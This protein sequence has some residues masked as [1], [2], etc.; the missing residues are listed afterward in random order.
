MKSNS[1]RN[2]ILI[3]MSEFIFPALFAF[4]LTLIF[5]VAAIRFFPKWGLMDRP[6][7]YGLKRKPIPYYGGLILVIVFVITSLLFVEIDKH[8]LGVILGALM[9]AGISFLDDLRNINPWIRLLVQILAAVTIV[10]SGIGI[11]SITN[12]LGGVIEL[13]QFELSIP[14]GDDFYQFTIL[15][16]LF[17]IIWIVLIVNTMNFLDGLNGLVSGIGVIASFTVFMLSIRPDNLIDQTTV[18]TLAIILGTV[19]LAFW[20]FDFHPAKILMGDTGSMFIGFL[21]AVFAIFS[22][23]KI[24]TA[25]L[26]LGFPILDAF[27]VITRRIVRGRSP[28]QGDLKHL[29]HRLLEVGLTER[30]A[31]ILM[32]LLSAFFGLSAIFLGSLQKLFLIVAM[33]IIMVIMATIVVYY[34]FKRI[35]SL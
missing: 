24:A 3:D 33:G 19:C 28:M 15:A 21:L 11:M 29:H 27:W 4:G 12:P 16:D 17:T 10:L 13:N 5:T 34:G 31:L 20:L 2:L 32:Y 30:K 14:I 22:G 35:K 6:H 9:I 1:G 7:K 23:G 25:F 8:V 26:V 18:A